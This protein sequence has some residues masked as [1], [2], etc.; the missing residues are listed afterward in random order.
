MLAGGWRERRMR[1]RS[2]QSS[3]IHPSCHL[4]ESVLTN[5]SLSIAHSTFG[6]PNAALHACWPRPAVGVPAAAAE[7]RPQSS[8]C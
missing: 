6:T 5:S 4:S 7:P 2:E 8:I 3:P 1:R